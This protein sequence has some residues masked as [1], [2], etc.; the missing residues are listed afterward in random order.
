[1]RETNKDSKERLQRLKNK[2]RKAYFFIT[3]Y[4]VSNGKN[5]WLIDNRCT[6]HMTHDTS[7]FTELNETYAVK[8]K[9]ANG[10]YVDVKGR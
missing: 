1:M 6:S 7:I 8:V 5:T 2:L 4:D 10:D 9:I 3:C